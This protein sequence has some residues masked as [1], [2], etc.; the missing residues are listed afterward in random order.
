MRQRTIRW[1]GKL[2]AEV[3]FLL[4][5][6]LYPFRHVNWGLDLWDTGYNYAN[7]TYMGLEHMD[8][9]W[10]FSTY[11]ANAVGHFLTRLP[12]GGTLVGMNVYT[13]LFVSLLAVMGYWFCTRKMGIPAWIVF[14]GEFAAVNLCWCP[15]ALLYNYLTYVLFLGC[16]ILLYKGLTENKKWVLYAAGICLGVNVFVR[17]SNL[18]EA[19]MIVAVWAYA[20]IE[21]LER[22]KEEKK[23]K[24]TEISEEADN[25]GNIVSGA[26]VGIMKKILAQAGRHTLW[27][28]AGYLS[29]LLVMLGYL[30]IRYGLGAYVEG[31][32][33]L[34]AMTDTATDY[35]A[36]S[37]LTGMVYPY[38]DML[39]W[40][41]RILV[42]V[43]AGMLL[44]GAVKYLSKYCRAIREN[45]AIVRLLSMVSRVIM[46]LITCVMILW[47]YRSKLIYLLF[48]GTGSDGLQEWYSNKFASFLFY[49]YDS[50]YRPC[51]LF[52]M[53]TIFIGVV[54]VLQKSCP[55]QEKLISGMVVL[56]V[57]LTALGSNNGVYPSINNLF[58]AAPYTLWQS[59]KFIQWTWKNGTGKVQWGQVISFLPV[60]Q[61][62][63]AMLILF[64][65]HGIGFGAMFVFA[66]ATG[67][68]DISAQVSDNEVL[69]GVKMNPERAEYM[70]ELTAYV[71]ENHLRGREVILYGYIPSLSFYLQ[72]PSAFNPWSDLDSYNVSVME[73]DLQELGGEIAEK[74]GEHP[75]VIAEKNYGV[76]E[77]EG[78]DGLLVL[79]ITE[80][81]AQ[82]ISED[83]KWQL[84][85]RFM[86]QHGYTLTFSN[87]KFYVW[88]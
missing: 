29:A 31:I 1:N 34:F 84:I 25:E 14:V 56:V 22:A 74:N 52:L 32:R 68:Q 61:A 67:V 53:L 43:A 35:K 57:I 42:F 28:M 79:G 88:Q 2:M 17:F 24:G 72:M 30:H 51:V 8:S 69:A 58:V 18:P 78:S 60:K 83:E 54:R 81:G 77:S 48:H 12:F 87:D 40:V 5:L 39:Y 41:E 4:I 47:L 9:M 63:C 45:T 65:V 26:K 73:S 23:K 38:L 70:T 6:I 10:L 59:V 33:R 62:L 36:A 46:I 86:K 64:F 55:K 20:V 7:F 75:V 44:F 66:E 15:T 13:G 27:C 16:V 82:K 49:S 71:E 50:M 85:S 80:E 11:L 19:A 3:C 37:M 76:Y 21:G